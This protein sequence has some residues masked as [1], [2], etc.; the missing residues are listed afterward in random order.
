MERDTSISR[1]GARQQPRKAGSECTSLAEKTC[2]ADG[3]VIP[4]GWRRDSAE[5]EVRRGWWEGEEEAHAGERGA[6]G[7]FGGVRFWYLHLV[8]PAH[9]K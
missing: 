9:P 8:R 6:G 5:Y 7:R 1:G 4:R 2:A 3:E